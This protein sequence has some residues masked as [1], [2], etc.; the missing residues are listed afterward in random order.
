[1]TIIAPSILSADFA[2][3]A[4]EIRRVEHAGA[5]WIHVDV[6]DGH[7]VPNITI[8]PAVVKSLRK[9]S[10]LPFDVHLMIEQPEQ[11]IHQFIEAGADRI[12]VHVEGCTHLHRLLRM[13]KDSGVKVGVALNPAT[14][15]HTIEHVL[16]DVDLVLL[17][18]V[19][20]GFGGQN[21]IPAV[22]P[23]IQKL[24]SILIEQK[25]DW[26]DIQVDGGIHSETANHVTKAGANV[27]VSGQYIFN[28][29]D[30]SEAIKQLRSHS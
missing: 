25:M 22:L 1:M 9:H 30:P 20:P 28:H 7:F 26:I 2:V 15:L 11:F 5:D 27:L 23:K 14:H 16:P 18:T 29:R 8:G 13:I 12:T 6:M 24:R 17:M 21:F 4:D 3:L 19:N 10:N